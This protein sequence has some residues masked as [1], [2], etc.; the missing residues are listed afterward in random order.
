MN[1]DKEIALH[2]YVQTERRLPFEYGVHDCGTFAAGALDLLTGGNLAPR[3]R[4][5]WSSEEEADQYSVD[6]GSVSRHLEREGCELINKA[7][8]Q[9]GD[10]PIIEH[11]PY[12]F[13]A[14]VCLGSKTAIN[15]SD[16]GVVLANTAQLNNVREVY[17]VQR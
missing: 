11:K 10:F 3:L 7:F 15:T 13:S 2:E 17:R 9:T 14:G 4:G 16:H 12:Q 8:I 6:H 5:K 1:P